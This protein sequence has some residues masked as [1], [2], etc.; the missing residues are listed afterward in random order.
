LTGNY[1]GGRGEAVYPTW[2][3]KDPHLHFL[4]LA[5]RGVSPLLTSQTI[6]PLIPLAFDIGQTARHA[7]F[8][9]SHMV[10]Y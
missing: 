5:P 3:Y 7:L 2:F 1:S 8:G 4:A 9:L 10:M 6:G